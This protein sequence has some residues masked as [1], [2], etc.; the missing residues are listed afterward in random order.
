MSPVEI[1]FSILSF[2]DA[3]FWGYVGFTLVILCGLYFT[4]KSR[5]FQFRV[6]L[7]PLKTLSELRQHDHTDLG[8]SPIR[9]YFASIGGMIGLGNLVAIIS[10]LLI[11]GPGALFWLW[12]ASFSGMLIKYAEI[13]LGIKYRVRHKTGYDGGS[14]YFLKHAFKTKI[15]A[16]LVS[17]LFLIYGVEVFQFLIVVDTVTHSFPLERPVVIAILLGL[18][19]YAGFG[20][21]KRLANICTLLMPTFVLVYIIMCFWIISHN[22]DQMPAV[23]ETVLKS[24]F[25][26]HAA[27]GGFAGSTF[28]MTAQKGISQAVY[29]GDIG[30]GYDSIIQSETKTPHPERQARM[31]I[32]ALITD[33]FICSLSLLLVLITGKWTQAGMQPSEYIPSVLADYFPY[34]DVFM[35]VLFFLAGFTT[36]IAYYA[37]GIKSARY[38]SPRYGQAMYMAYSAFAFV[39]FSF[40]QQNQVMLVMSVSGGFLMLTNLLGIMK[41]RKEIRFH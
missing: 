5:G 26:G 3:F 30:I 10:A 27:V 22:L 24:A 36:I 20:G 21:V 1:F 31:A 37:V 2:I 33:T 15:P 41:L 25:T 9:L 32:F 13:Y 11:G 19:F 7:S 29:S 6:L 14:I 16:M 12:I 34:M 17:F 18:V 28:I 4:W 38:L 39:F 40:H 35:T 23:L 8:V